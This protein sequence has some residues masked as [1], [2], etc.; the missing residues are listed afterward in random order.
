[1]M[2]RMGRLTRASTIVGLAI[3]I[4]GCK[5]KSPT[6]PP[7]ADQPGAAGAGADSE[8][9]GERGE[10]A[11]P[12]CAADGGEPWDG[13]AEGCLY[14][15]GGCCYPSPEAMC[16]AAGCAAEHCSIMESSPAQARCAEIP[17]TS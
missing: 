14:E 3:A 13:K 11:P 4:A 7:A 8:M 16:S 6:H 15:H 10:D 1:M 9:P 12:D 5:P 2:A 17:P